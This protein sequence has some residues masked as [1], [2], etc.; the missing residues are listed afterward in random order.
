MGTFGLRIALAAVRCSTSSYHY[1][2]EERCCMTKNEPEKKPGQTILVVD[3]DKKILQFLRSSLEETGFRVFIVESGEEALELL[4]LHTVDLVILDLEFPRSKIDG[5]DVCRKIQ[6]MHK[7]KRLPII[8]L[9]GQEG[10]ATQV[11]VFNLGA[12]DYVI[13][14]FDMQVFTARIQAVLRRSNQ[15]DVVQPI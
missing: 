14:P 5:I 6:Q 7:G 11:N 10:R 12:D 2:N 8:V 3:D 13:K 15:S 4:E 1:L 9:S